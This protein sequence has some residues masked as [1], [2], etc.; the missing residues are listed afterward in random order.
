MGSTAANQRLSQLRAQSVRAYLISKGVRP[1]QLTAQGF[2]KS[3]LLINPEASAQDREH[4][5]R[6]ELRVLVK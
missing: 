2:G 5:R 6:V 3:Q 4:N 1:E